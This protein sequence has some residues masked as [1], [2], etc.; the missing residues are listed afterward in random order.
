[1]C[2]HPLVHSPN[3]HYGWAGTGATAGHQEGIQVSLMAVTSASRRS[4]LAGG[5]RWSSKSNPCSLTWEVGVLA[6]SVKANSL[7]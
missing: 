4:A 6:A 3:S 1:M 7:F 2:L 5:R